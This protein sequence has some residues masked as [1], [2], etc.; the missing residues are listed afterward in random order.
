MNDDSDS[1]NGNERSERTDGGGW[2]RRLGK[3]IA[4]GP[5]SR[6]DI[7]E[8]LSEASEEG[9][10]EGEAL[11]IAE[12]VASGGWERVSGDGIADAAALLQ[13]GKAG[14]SL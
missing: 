1:S 14:G 4:G 8:F 7:L 12:L 11:P 6:S 10:I 5:R 13:L 3:S 9:L 2:F